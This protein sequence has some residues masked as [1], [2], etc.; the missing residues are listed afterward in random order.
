MFGYRSLIIFGIAL[1]GL[2]ANS[3]LPKEG[4]DA[5]T[6]LILKVSF[7]KDS[8]ILGE[9][10]T[11]HLELKN[12]GSNSVVILDNFSVETGHILLK[13]IRSDGVTFGFGNPLWGVKDWIGKSTV[14]PFGSIKTTAGILWYADEKM[15][16]AFRLKEKGEYTIVAE[17]SVYYDNGDLDPV[18]I[19]SAPV[20]INIEDPLGEDLE[21]WN[22]IKGDGNFAFFLQE[23]DLPGKRSAPEQLEIFSRTVEDILNKYPTSLYAPYI[24][25][26]FEK[27]QASENARRQN[28]NKLRN[29]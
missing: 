29:Q 21:V 20:R 24:R 4:G 14:M 27:L 23:G 18:R 9:P 25:S 19:Q 11:A 16:A 10:I 5:E 17:Y 6:G 8:Y 2:V 1:L 12:N 3:V 15:N 28:I 26:A 13:G 7:P 22:R